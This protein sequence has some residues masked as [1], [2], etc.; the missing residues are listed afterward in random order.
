MADQ[1]TWTEVYPLY[2]TLLHKATFS[3]TTSHPVMDP[4][5]DAEVSFH[6]KENY[7]LDLLKKNLFTIFI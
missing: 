6:T 5:K 2:F 3:S 1:M 4:R 7:V